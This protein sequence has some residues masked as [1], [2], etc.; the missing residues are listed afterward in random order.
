MITNLCDK[1]E[2]S[3]VHD[4]V[5]LFLFN[6]A[7]LT[8]TETEVHLKI[9]ELGLLTGSDS[10]HIILKPHL[11]DPAITCQ[12]TITIQGSTIKPIKTGIDRI[13]HALYELIR[14]LINR[15]I[16]DKLKITKTTLLHLRLT[17]ASFSLYGYDVM[18]DL[19]DKGFTTTNPEN[20]DYPEEGVQ[21]HD[22][23]PRIVTAQDLVNQINETVIRRQKTDDL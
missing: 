14:S 20:C 11:Y 15:D 22:F 9:P 5:A 17:R 10:L 19:T 4:I 21:E 3:P 6:R 1:L 18:L 12:V 23:D 2:R 8:K 7:T 13:D 16:Y